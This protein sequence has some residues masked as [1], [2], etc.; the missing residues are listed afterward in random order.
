MK[1]IKRSIGFVALFIFLA[2]VGCKRV[3]LHHNLQEIEADEIL[4]MLHQNGI[5]ARKIK[6]VAGQEVSWT[7][8][9]SEKDLPKARQILISNSMPRRRELGL[10]GV[11]KEKGLIPTPDEQKARF[12]LALKG[13]II[14]SLQKIP[15][16]VDSD[17]VLNVPS[18][19]EFADLDPVK[20]RPTASVVVKTRNDE[21]IAQT[22]TEA[23]VQ[24]FVANS[25]PNMDPND[26]AVIVTRID[27]GAAGFAPGPMPPTPFAPLIPS[28]QVE[29]GE[30]LPSAGGETVELA[31]LKMTPDSIGRFKGYIIGLLTLLVGVSLFLLFNIVRLNRLRLKVQRASRPE[32]MALGG[33]ETTGLLGEGQPGQG[34]EGTFDVGTRQRSV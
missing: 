31:G 2:L 32:R 12:L 11:Y 25:I 21:R 27:T 13:E 10:S 16:V 17:V 7:V 34:V 6:E 3:E 26:V 30:L 9:V 14:N 29:E 33:G 22:V 24:R 18:E 20:K 19:S 8:S 15:G 23:K 1:M 28:E 4:V 5:E